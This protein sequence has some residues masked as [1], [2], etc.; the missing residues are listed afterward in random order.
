ML[1]TTVSDLSLIL[2]CFFCSFF[3]FD[4]RIKH[5]SIIQVDFTVKISNAALAPLEVIA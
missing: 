3:F 2:F 1:H 5:A 4:G